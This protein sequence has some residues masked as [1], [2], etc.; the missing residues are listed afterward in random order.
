M[1]LLLF[2]GGPLD[3][4]W[5]KNSERIFAIIECWFPAQSAGE[6]L[7]RMITK[8]GPHSMPAGR[9]PATWPATNTKVPKYTNAFTKLSEI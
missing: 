4:T 7:Y 3:I 9:L 2:N 6:A 8:T 5:A 1:I